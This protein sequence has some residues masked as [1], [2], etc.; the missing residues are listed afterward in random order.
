M[1]SVA[2]LFGDAVSWKGRNF[3]DDR[4]RRRITSY[5]YIAEMEVIRLPR[6][7]SEQFARLMID[8]PEMTPAVE[9]A[10]A[11]HRRLVRAR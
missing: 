4:Y 3:S 11:D 8:P 10:F 7:A 2:S 9:Q 6:E 1:F 5:H